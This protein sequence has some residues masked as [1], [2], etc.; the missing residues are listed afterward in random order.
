MD[1]PRVEIR[2]ESAKRRGGR[3][4]M[5]YLGARPDPLVAVRSRWAFR[6][7]FLSIVVVAGASLFR[8]APADPNEGQDALLG[9]VARLA[10]NH[11]PVG[12][13]HAAFEGNC[14]ECHAPFVPVVDGH[15]LA[16]FDPEKFGKGNLRCNGCHSPPPHAESIASHEANCAA[17]HP[18]HRGR[19]VDLRRAPDSS[20]T[21]CH[22]DLKSFAEAKG[23]VP[24]RKIASSVTEFA[25]GKHPPFPH[26]APADRQSDPGGLK[27][28]HRLHL[29][30]GVAEKPGPRGTRVR[31]LS[32]DALKRLGGAPKP[33]DFVKLDCNYCH[34]TD[35]GEANLKGVPVRP[36]GANFMPINYQRHCADCHKL[37]IPGEIVPAARAADAGSPLRIRPVEAPHGL[38]PA[39]VLSF[40]EGHYAAE[41][42]R[43]RPDIR[44]QFLRD[45]IKDADPARRAAFERW[46]ANAP[47]EFR[48]AAFAGPA[49]E[50]AK[51]LVTSK[52]GCAECHS[53]RAA[54]DVKA[55]GNSKSADLGIDALL[56]GDAWKTATVRPTAVPQI[57]QPHARFS[58]LAHS[59]VKCDDC[60]QY[61]TAT[62]DL[63]RARD[64]RAAKDV[65]IPDLV[66][67]VRCH[68]PE[69]KI[70]GLRSDCALC[71]YYHGHDRPLA[72]RAGHALP[73][74]RRRD[75][76][77]FLRG[78]QR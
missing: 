46:F 68:G 50:R 67:C 64:S 24:K 53:F 71:H 40:I 15:W 75:V 5:G 56:V 34:E 38:T 29:L 25:P 37:E 22:A 59:A 30:P 55:E 11:G 31:E 69:S 42:L 48:S 72:G 10:A 12:S 3:I 52:N 61:K 17:C 74:E 58:H 23:V 76:I 8:F 44:D 14:D 73:E 78:A 19:A 77:D 21:A 39:K 6:S 70:P 63:V 49:A 4:K 13:H 9:K 33:E 66:S 27:F 65:L 62:G 18:E 36:T 7:L 57:W 32:K 20:C 35:F 28:N 43:A 45:A 16:H 54:P 1:A 51:L 60:H 26:T 47:A 2:R 41:A